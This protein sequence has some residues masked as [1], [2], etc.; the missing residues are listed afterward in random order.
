MGHV[1]SLAQKSLH[2]LIR[3]ELEMYLKSQY[4]GFKLKKLPNERVVKLGG[5]MIP[6]DAPTVIDHILT[7]CKHRAGRLSNLRRLLPSFRNNE[8]LI[9]KKMKRL[10]LDRWFLYEDIKKSR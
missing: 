8:R 3:G 6:P 1:I 7:H 5:I 9:R 10:G 2:E 4:P